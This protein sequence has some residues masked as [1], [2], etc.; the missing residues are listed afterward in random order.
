[1]DAPALAV[2][3]ILFSAQ[4]SYVPFKVQLGCLEAHPVASR[5]TSPSLTLPSTS[6]M[7]Q[8]YPCV[9]HWGNGL[10]FK[11]SGLLSP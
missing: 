10:R 1:M 2:P 8:W 7:P 6:H 5:L 3:A 11:Y 4:D 9:L